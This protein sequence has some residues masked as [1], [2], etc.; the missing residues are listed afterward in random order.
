MNLK[1]SFFYQIIFLFFQ[2]SFSNIQTNQRFLI[3]STE[4]NLIEDGS[5]YINILKIEYKN[6]ENAQNLL[7]I[8]VEI[9]AKEGDNNE[10]AIGT[11]N[12]TPCR[13]QLTHFSVM[14]SNVNENGKKQL[15][16]QE[17]IDI[18]NI[19]FINICLIVTYEENFHVGN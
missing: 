17:N 10:L 14:N 5:Q 16:L 4:N 18:L 6:N 1:I 2:Y 3:T 7:E 15:N 8:L 13:G 12:E 9:N 19:E 11:V